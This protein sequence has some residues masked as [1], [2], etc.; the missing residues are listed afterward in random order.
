[1]R[2]Q[3]LLLLLAVA[4]CVVTALPAVMASAAGALS[5]AP[6]V[7]YGLGG[8]PA[9]LASAD[10]NGDGR[11]DLVA[12]AGS[13]VDVL[14]GVGR[15]GFATATR[16]PLEHRPAAIAL[17][18]LDGSG[19]EDVVTANRDGTV[20]VLLGTGDGSFVIKGT[21]PSGASASF[22]VVAGDLSGDS[23]PDVATAGGDDG[24]SIL[25]GD[26]TGGLLDPLRLPVGARCWLVVAEDFDL[27]G[28]LDLAASRYEWEDY[29][30]FAVLLAD[31]AGGFSAPA[32]FN[33][34]SVDSS[35]HGLAAC[36]LNRDAIPDLAA[37]YGYEGGSVNSFLGD[38]LGLFVS[39]G[40]TVFSQGYNEA[41][42]L[43]VAD[44]N[45]D[46]ADDVVTIGQRPGS[47]LSP[48]GPP[49]LYIMLSRAAEGVSFEPTSFLAGRLPGEVIAADL[50]VDKKP[51][52]A[53]TDPEYRSLSV[54]L[55]GALPVLTGISP[56][57]GRIGSVVTLTGRHFSLRDAVVRFDA[58]TAT[59]YVSSS[60]SK[61]KVRVPLGTASGSVKVTVTTLIGRSAPGSFF[62]L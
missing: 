8:K 6:P 57:Q 47:N 17:A 59:D 13:G 5:F 27:D 44:L 26:G 19:T 56:A 41:W 15:S 45:R 20:T 18:D 37:V 42:G 2:K 3:R 14:L 30:G 52:L 43:A 39:A 40:H 62:R 35:P 53:T 22:D 4:V 31:G 29:S 25:R 12:S 32:F 51:D 10:L 23:V 58:T 11:P 48:P 61:I 16:T 7:H 36:R 55:R 33:A 38:G 9:D 49:R 24:V 54:R 28:S 1:M 50:N 60:D 34:G 21:Y 46:G